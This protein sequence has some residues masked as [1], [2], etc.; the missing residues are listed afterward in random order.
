MG[1]RRAPEYEKEQYLQLTG[2]S[3]PSKWLEF[4]RST[5]EQCSQMPKRE[6]IGDNE[7]KKRITF[8]L[9]AS[10]MNKNYPIL[11]IYQ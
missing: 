2:K 7:S 11:P 4:L 3:E 6:K 1:R 9:I 5:V 10:F 8:F